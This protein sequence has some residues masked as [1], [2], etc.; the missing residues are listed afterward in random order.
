MKNTEEPFDFEQFA[1]QAAE[2]LKSGK[3]M[4]GREGVF[5][6]LLKRIIEASLEGELDAHLQQTRKAEKNRRNGGK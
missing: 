2:D 6:P 1:R 5:T 4:V 3:S